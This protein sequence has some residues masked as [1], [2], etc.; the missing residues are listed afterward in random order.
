MQDDSDVAEGSPP[1]FGQGSPCCRVVAKI[2]A[3]A[4]VKEDASS[5][6]SENI[7]TEVECA[8]MVQKVVAQFEDTLLALNTRLESLEQNSSGQSSMT[9]VVVPD[10]NNM[11][12]AASE[13]VHDVS[14]GESY[15]SS[16]CSASDLRALLDQQHERRLV[17]KAH[18]RKVRTQ[19][20]EHQPAGRDNT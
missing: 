9:P 5:Q 6:T 2:T 10:P 18:R 19:M 12:D 8:K 14:M 13:H 15:D 7:I 17:L 16:P 4:A 3:I 11:T 1:P 20:V